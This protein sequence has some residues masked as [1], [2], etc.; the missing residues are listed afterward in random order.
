[1]STE[2]TIEAAC[3]EGI[4]YVGVDCRITVK[5]LKRWKGEEPA[6]HSVEG[7]CGQNS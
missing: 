2:Q 3:L 7:D 4:I 6:E 5:T 1:M